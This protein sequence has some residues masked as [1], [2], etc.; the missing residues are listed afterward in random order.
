MDPLAAATSS[1]AAVGTIGSHFM[2]DGATYVKGASLGFGGLDFY[3]TGRAGVLGPV[4]ADVVVAALAFFE[5]GNV[6]TLWEQGQGVMPPVDAAREFAACC[7]AWAEE[8]VPDD[9]DAARLADLAG[10]AATGARPACAPVFAG[11]RAVPVPE[12]PKAAAVHQMN[13]LREL[14]N[15]LHSAAVVSVGLSPLQ[16]LS[17]RSPHMVALFGWPEPA[18]IEGLQPVWE[19]A[20]RRTDAAIAHAYDALDEAER[21]ELVE[22]A[23]ALH[24]ATKG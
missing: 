5:P 3:I 20:E 9:L 21:A 23:E 11:W 18:A 6:R 24:Q 12:S 17:V 10:K 22:L 14:R 16:A 2:L 1:A 15:G 4:D 19:D 7:E 8:H 13:V